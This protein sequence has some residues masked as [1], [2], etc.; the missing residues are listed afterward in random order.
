[1]AHP[2]LADA[3][4]SAFAEDV[5]LGLTRVPQ[6]ELPSKY[7]YDA[8]GS[9]LFDVIT[10]LPEYGVTR[11][12]ERVLIAHAADLARLVPNTTRVAELGSGSGRK[13]RRIL[14]AL[15]ARR[16]V[17]Y[18]PIEISPAALAQCERALRDLE[19]VRVE[20]QAFEYLDGLKRVADARGRSDERLL[21]MFLG[22]TI[23][24]FRRLAAAHFLRDVRHLMR[25]GD[26]LLLGA[27]LL[28]PEPVL[29]EAYD[30]PAGVTAAFNLN[31]LGRLNRELGADFDL[32]AFEHVAR[33]DPVAR[34]IEMHLRARS[35]QTVTIGAADLTVE[36]RRGE[37]IWTE[38]SHKYTLDDIAHLGD[39]AGFEQLAQWTDAEWPFAETLF[40]AR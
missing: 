39:V 31:M 6:K 22:S 24:N 13:T 40:V 30:D 28:K 14:E 37:T 3:V 29:I 7:L 8:V 1:M 26:A 27:D 11:A 21:V 35:D 23:G 32:R 34:A 12:E 10:V 17:T 18:C 36:F 20:G 25:A 5:R 2:V 16:D 15:T 4:R 33:F 19:R 38:A 9:A